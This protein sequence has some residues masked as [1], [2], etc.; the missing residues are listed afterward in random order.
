MHHTRSHV[1]PLERPRVGVMLSRRAGL[2]RFPCSKGPLSSLLL[3]QT[4]TLRTREQ[5]P[6]AGS[7]RRVLSL[8]G[9]LWSCCTA[10]RCRNYVSISK[11]PLP[12]GPLFPYPQLQASACPSP[13]GEAWAYLVLEPSGSSLWVK[14]R[15]RCCP[16]KAWH[17]PLP[18]GLR[19]LH[20]G[21]AG[22]ETQLSGPQNVPAQRGSGFPLGR[23]EHFC[24]W[25]RTEARLWGPEGGLDFDVLLFPGSPSH[26]ALL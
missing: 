23:R 19:D 1:A 10:L 22:G 21:L 16:K 13:A 11:K 25:Q 9:P 7:L 26:S 5:P 4:W 8:R 20:S 18:F 3:C 24:R 14:P 12:P 6:G 15:A 17:L 2:E